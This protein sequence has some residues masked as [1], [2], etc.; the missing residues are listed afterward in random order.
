MNF[1]ELCKTPESLRPFKDADFFLIDPEVS[2]PKATHVYEKVGFKEIAE[3]TSDFNPKLHIMMQRAVGELKSN[4]E[5]LSMNI[6]QR[7]A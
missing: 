3:F 7:L 6:D 1:Q 4:N 2:K 5:M